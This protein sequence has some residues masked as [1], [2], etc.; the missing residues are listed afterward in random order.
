MIL[1][2]IIPMLLFFSFF[3]VIAGYFYP[4]NIL[5]NHHKY[6]IEHLKTM[7][8][9]YPEHPSPFK[10]IIVVGL[11]ISLNTLYYF[12]YPKLSLAIS[13]NIFATLCITLII[14]DYRNNLLPESITLSLILS[15]LVFSLS[16]ANPSTLL[17]LIKG[18]VVSVVF[19]LLTS[20]PMVIFKKTS[21]MAIGDFLFIAGIGVWIG[22][23]KLYQ[24]GVLTVCFAITTGVILRSRTIPL[25]IALGL[26]AIICT[27]I[28][29]T[30]ETIL[31]Y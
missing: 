20:V 4:R 29:E 13:Y 8:D 6:C 21:P 25:G 3:A 7:P 18:G 30:I 16:P 11:I 27:L 12:I 10:V 14:S 15:G 26:A 28:P 17:D 2:F 9:A 1:L 22:E 19:A 31:H 5:E 23:N 24:F